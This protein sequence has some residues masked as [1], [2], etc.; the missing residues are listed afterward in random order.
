[1]KNKYSLT[2]D[3]WDEQELQSIKDVIATNRYTMGNEVECFENLFAKH[4]KSKYAIMVNSGSSANLLAIA[5]L[6]FRKDNFLVKGDEVIVPAVS[7][8]TTYY[9]L[10]QYGLK[11]K[12]VDIDLNTLNF[13]LLSLKEAIS[14][15]TKLIVAVN[16]LGNPNDY[17]HINNLIKEKNIILF[18]DNC[19]SLGAKLNNRFTGTFGLIGTYSFFYSHHISTMEGGMITTDNEELYHIL[20]S[21]RA[22]GWTRN[23]PKKNKI[24]GTKSDFSFEESF[25]FVLPGYNLRP[26][27]F[28]GKIGQIQLRKLNNFIKERRENAKYFLSKAARNPLITTQKEIG[29]SSW[30]GFSII[31]DPDLQISR[32]KLINELEKAGIETRPIIGGNFTNNEVIKYFDYSIHNNLNNANIVDQFGFFVGNHHFKIR[33]NID[34]LFKILDRTLK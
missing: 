4:F 27:E 34:Y 5:S 31:I 11:L 6:F 28:S 23:L 2:S 24:T 17:L 15:K 7:W 26:L 18:E 30:F 19:E 22:H 12:F 1:M 32:N 16:V 8:S 14:P 3:T 10:Q 25:K 20:L 13:D 9:P 33:D 29:E 21:I